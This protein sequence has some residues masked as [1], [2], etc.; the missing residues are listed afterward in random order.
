[1]SASKDMKKFKTDIRRLKAA[2]EDSSA[3]VSS[4]GDQTG[5]LA[6]MAD[7]VVKTLSSGGKIL[8]AGNGGSAA[9]AL[10]MSE[11]LVGR[12]KGNRR[13]LP[14]VCLADDPTALTCIGNDFGFDRIFSRQVEGLGRAGDIL[15]VFS[16]SG[17]AEN[18]RLAI[19]AAKALKL[20]TVCLLGRDGG[21]IAGMGDYELIVKSTATERIQEA[22]QVIIHL[23]LDAVE[24]SFS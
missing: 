6:A 4:L 11:E 19:C 17:N 1:M 14:A 9:E 15:V 3:L 13:S 20:K 23:I 7:F 12:F 18:L 2:I 8:T 21:R 5:V 16:T 24:Q 10:H 22:H